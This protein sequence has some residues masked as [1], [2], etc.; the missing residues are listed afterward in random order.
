[1]IFFLEKHLLITGKREETEKI[2]YISKSAAIDVPMA[3]H[4]CFYGIFL[5]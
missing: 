2:F 3:A 4:D 1:M 5:S